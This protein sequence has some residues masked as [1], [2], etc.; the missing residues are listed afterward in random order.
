MLGER[1]EPFP[2]PLAQ[3]LGGRAGRIEGIL[4]ARSD[5]LAQGFAR[6]ADFLKIVGRV[7]DALFKIVEK[8]TG[9]AKKFGPAVKR[10]SD[11]RMPGLDEALPAFMNGNEILGELPAKLDIAVR[12]VR[13]RLKR[14]LRCLWT[15]RRGQA[16]NLRGALSDSRVQ[17]AQGAGNPA[18]DGL[19]LLLLFFRKW[20]D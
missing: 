2:Q 1:V 18:D 11:F 16:L 3:R 20:H 10:R 14:L 19:E 13:R 9:P 4:D 5:C 8:L 6:L 12:L 17:F 7:R 15:D